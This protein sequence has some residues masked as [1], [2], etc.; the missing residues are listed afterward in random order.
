MEDKKETFQYTYSAK[1]QAEINSI[2]EK[3]LP[4][5]ESKLERLR[6]LDQ[7]STRPGTVAALLLGVVGLTLFG[8]GMCCTMVWADRLFIPGIV[9]GLLGIAGICGAYPL[10]GLITKKRREK[11][12]PQILKLTEELSRQDS[13]DRKNDGTPL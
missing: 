2:R 7:S 3:Y 8:V 5:A 6:K 10:Y 12:A 11:I 13:A 9:I 1:Q 4:R